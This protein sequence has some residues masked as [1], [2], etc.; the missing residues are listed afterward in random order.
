MAEYFEEE[1]QQPIDNGVIYH[2]RG[3]DGGSGWSGGNDGFYE[4][5]GVYHHGDHPRG[6]MGDEVGEGAQAVEGEES[7]DHLQIN[8]VYGHQTM[9]I[10]AQ[11][12]GSLKDFAATP[13][14]TTWK[15]NPKILEHMK[16]NTRVTNRSN[17]TKADL[18][19]DL[20]KVI[21]LDAHLIDTGNSFKTNI[22][23]RCTGMQ[24]KTFTRDNLFDWVLIYL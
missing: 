14:L 20:T 21:I 17:A 7:N 16:T 11:I 19:G 9:I 23:I 15:M 3:Y 10:F 1:E 18:E 4:E 13:S 24:P 6:Y 8:D 2:R 5:R 12:Q 22:G